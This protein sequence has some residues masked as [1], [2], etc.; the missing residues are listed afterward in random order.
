M[1]DIAHLTKKLQNDSSFSQQIGLELHWAKL[2]LHASACQLEKWRKVEKC[3]LHTYSCSHLASEAG[4]STSFALDGKQKHENENGGDAG[5][6]LTQSK[7]GHPASSTS[8]LFAS[9]RS[10]RSA[11]DNPLAACPFMNMRTHSVLHVKVRPALTQRQRGA[12]IRRVRLRRAFFSIFLASRAAFF[13]AS[14]L[15]F[16]SWSCSHST[17]S[18]ITDYSRPQNHPNTDSQ[19]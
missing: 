7:E 14:C 17:A 4:P 10:C 1:S 9:R 12:L 11:F 19:G 5:N 2:R 15:C 8:L 16:K 6:D 18:H 3:S 13:A